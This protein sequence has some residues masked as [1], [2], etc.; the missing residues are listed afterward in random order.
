MNTTLLRRGSASAYLRARH[1]LVFAPSTLAKLAVTGGGPV[2]RRVGRFPVYTPND[3]D[4][5]VTSKLSAPMLS[6]S[7]LAE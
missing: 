4:D 3:L 7:K 5:W 1:G 2:F 6:T